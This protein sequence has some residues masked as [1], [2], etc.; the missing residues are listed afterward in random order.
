MSHYPTEKQVS[1]KFQTDMKR[2]QCLIEF[3]LALCSYF[4]SLTGFHTPGAYLCQFPL[5]YS[6]GMF[7]LHKTCS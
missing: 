7:K 3:F 5:T 1:L 2:L 4:N 6:H